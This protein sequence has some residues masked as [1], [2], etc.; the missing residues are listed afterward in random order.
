METQ[1]I[2]VRIMKIKRGRVVRSVASLILNLFIFS[3]PS[4]SP[5]RRPLIG[6]AH[7]IPTMGSEG[8]A[9]QRWAAK[10]AEL[11]RHTTRMKIRGSVVS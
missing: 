8:C 10:A 6:T 7:A 11:N 5:T 9:S 2:V 3:K 1:R 4:I